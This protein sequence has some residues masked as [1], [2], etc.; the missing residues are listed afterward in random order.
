ME[1]GR[2]LDV[3]IV[4][5]GISGLAA[6]HE[7]RAAG[8]SVCILEARDRVGGRIFSAHDPVCNREIPL[9][10]E[11]IHGK[12]PEI[13][14]PLQAA[15]VAIKEVEGDHW[16]VR[17]G[18]L[19]LCN[20]FEQVDT[21]L[22]K[23]ED[24]GPDESFEQFLARYPVKDASG[25]EV[26]R[27][28]RQYVSGFNAAETDKVG[29]HW[30]VQQ[31]RAEERIEG[32]RVF[33]PANG[34]GELLR[35]FAEKAS[36]QDGLLRTS[37]CVTEAVWTKGSVDVAFRDS[38]GSSSLKASRVLITVPLGVLKA[39][40]PQP[41]AIEFSPA[42]PSGFQEALNGLE[43]GKAIRVTLRFQE[44]FWGKIVP[45]LS[46]KTLANLSFL[47]TENELFPA[48][49]TAM[50]ERAPIITGWAPVHSAERL[51]GQSRELVVERCVQSLS[52]S[53]NVPLPKI[54]ESL[55]A[56]YVHDWQNDPFSRGAY[57]YGKIG[58][59]EATRILAEPID[60]T[61]F[62]AGEH[63]DFS[64]HSGTVHGAIASGV[65]SAKVILGQ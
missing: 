46:R 29:V 24:S 61:I 1:S 49:W 56:A 51:S 60:G 45:P 12:P 40:A 64:G 31:M 41:G 44:R 28:A 30:L 23:M 59:D 32:G 4:G 36:L 18:R 14:A 50:P 33:R 2:H 58:S 7:L 22:M 38:T 13:W 15:G 48:W 55:G 27:R 65:R 26:R 10:A 43:M 47:F 53:L 42:L 34:Y 17:E 62:F 39:P 37:T 3:I 11:F 52:A 19:C 20:F 5:A 25:E 54:L 21:I 35:V 6:A 57:S 9:G 8:L 63:T 16:C